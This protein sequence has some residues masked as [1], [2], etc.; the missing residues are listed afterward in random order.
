MTR[1]AVCLLLVC[2][3]V[4]RADAPVDKGKDKEKAAKPLL[5]AWQVTYFEGMKVGHVHT[6]VTQDGTGDKA[7][8]HTR[9]KMALVIKRYGSVLPL[10]IDQTCVESPEGKVLS[11]SLTQAIG[12]TPKVTH[13]GVVMG[14]AILI[15]TK[16]D[17]AVRKAAWDD[18]VVGLYAQET[19]FKKKK[20]KSGD[21]IKLVSYELLLP[22]TLT[23][24]SVVKDFEAVDRLEAKDADG[25]PKIVRAS[26]KLLRV[27]ATPD[28]FKIGGTEVRLPAKAI[29][30]DANLMPVREQFEMPGLGSLTMYTTTKDAALK[31]GIAPD[32]LP[33]IG[34]NISIPLKQ[35]IDGPYRTTE[36]VYKITLKEKLPDVFTK[37]RR[38]EVREEKD[39]TFE[40]V[41]K[42]V[43]EP[44]TNDE[45]KPPA[46][47]YYESNTYIDSDDTRVKNLTRAVVRKESDD[48]K[49]ALLLEKWVHDK[50]KVSTALG[51]PTASQVAKDLEG[52]CRQHALLLAAMCRAAGVPSRTAIGLIYSREAGRSPFFG[53]H[54]WVEVWVKGRWVALDA[55]LGQGGVAA[56]HLKMGHHSW[57][58]TTTLAPLLPISR[59]L[60]KI[61]I[62]VVESK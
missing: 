40:L 42:A 61:Q 33:D 57:D 46:K 24:Q 8:I 38:Q 58:K 1:I 23:I 60:G 5:D 54:M 56:T 48:W 31:E 44:G 10:E 45:A 41:V 28:A 21:K 12:E 55:I 19:I 59:T 53:F 35:T 39:N 25:N 62:E 9:R 22:G 43:R 18:E 7:R 34:L 52:D 36:V 50:M 51:V 29:W 20:A 47:E 15:K 16:G 27:D 30:L 17:E 26:T 49:K 13:T 32:R 11:L 6:L 14:N 4:A 2:P 37:D 3:L